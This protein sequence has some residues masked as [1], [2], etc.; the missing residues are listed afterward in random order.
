MQKYYHIIYSE[1]EDETIG[2]VAIAH[3]EVPLPHELI[4]ELEGLYTLPFD[5]ELK[6][7]RYHNGSFVEEDLDN[8][9]L[10][11]FPANNLGCPLMSSK[12][13]EIIKQNLSGQEQIDWISAKI[14]V[15]GKEVPFFI[16]RFNKELDV[17]DMEQTMFVPETDMVIIPSFSYNKIKFLDLFPLPS[18]GDNL[19]MITTDIY[20]SERV[21]VALE[22]EGVSG[23]TFD[24]VH[25]V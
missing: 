7:L 10:C 8:D 2:N 22:K 20:I 21:K 25:V 17:L 11:D 14:I 9:I 13:A 18:K 4:A 5:L 16:P 15:S 24:I 6:K 12:M 3:G 19:W 23:V 1:D